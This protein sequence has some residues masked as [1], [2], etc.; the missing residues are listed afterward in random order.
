LDHDPRWVLGNIFSPV[1]QYLTLHGLQQFQ[2]SLPMSAVL[3]LLPPGSINCSRDFCRV[4]NAAA[5]EFDRPDGTLD[6]DR[7][8]Y[9][10]ISTSEAGMH[11]NKAWRGW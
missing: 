7:A 1:S 8:A 5:P 4:L 10:R 3:S 6:V 11:R 9:V 2:I